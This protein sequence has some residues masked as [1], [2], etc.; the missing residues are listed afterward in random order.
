MSLYKHDMVH[1][2]L[3]IICV[4]LIA[5]FL[6][7]T[8]LGKREKFSD[9]LSLHDRRTFRDEKGN[10]I[11]H[12]SSER[13]EQEAIVRHIKSDDVVLELGP[14]YGTTSA[15]ILDLAKDAVLIEPDETILMALVDNLRR[16]GHDDVKIF[17][18]FLGDKDKFLSH[19][20]YSSSIREEP[21]DLCT[22]VKHITMKELEHNL[23]I[24]FNVIVADCEG[25]FPELVKTSDLSHVKKILLET[26][27]PLR[28]DYTSMNAELQK[29]GFELLEDGFHQCWVK[30]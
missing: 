9:V 16:A 2:L 28:A 14:R 30:T 22:R 17:S 25:C 19:D 4:V 1:N 26:D 8:V 3:L 7:T 18:G 20:S 27:M 29:L 5:V 15:L 13:S 11:D 23:Q 24:K 12:K 10:K 21:C 6:I